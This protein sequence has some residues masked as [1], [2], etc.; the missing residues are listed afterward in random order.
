MLRLNPDGE[1]VVSP[2]TRSTSHSSQASFIPTYSSS[3]ASTEN[4]LEMP[5]STTIW[6]G[7]AFIAQMSD[8]LAITAL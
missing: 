5:S 8:R 6:V 4:L 7:R 1:D 2:P 3:R